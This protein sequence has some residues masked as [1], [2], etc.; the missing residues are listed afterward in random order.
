[1]VKWYKYLIH[2]N[3]SEKVSL[4][5]REMINTKNL[6]VRQQL[7]NEYFG[8]FETYLDF[9]KYFIR[10]VKDDDYKCFHEAIFN[11]AQKMYFDID[12]PL[13]V[14]IEDVKCNI[15]LK[16]KVI[17]NKQIYTKDEVVTA[18]KIL[19][20]RIKIVL[21]MVKDT[22]ILVFNSN[23]DKKCSYHIVIDRWCC[24]D[25]LDAKFLFEEIMKDYPSYYKD[26]IDKSL[27]KNLQ[28]F[29]T[30]KSKK[31]NDNRIKELDELSTWSSKGI[32]F[33]NEDQ[34][35]I[36]ILGASLVTN[37]SYCSVL[38]T[39][40]IEVEKS[41]YTG[42]EITLSKGEIDNISKL[43]D[44]SFSISEVKGTMILLKRLRP[45]YCEMCKTVHEHQNPYL[46]VTQDMNV[47]FHCRRTG[48]EKDKYLLGNIGS[49]EVPK[50]SDLLI[51]KEET[52]DTNKHD[53]V[54]E[55]YKIYSKK[56]I[57]EE[58]VKEELEKDKINEEVK[59]KVKVISGK[60]LLN[61]LK[62]INNDIDK[63]KK[64]S[65]DEKYFNS[66]EYV[67][68]LPINTFTSSNVNINDTK[69]HTNKKKYDNLLDCNSI[70]NIKSTNNK[71][72]KSP[73]IISDFFSSK[74]IK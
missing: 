69:Y 39:F 43:F 65:K 50:L 57:K 41:I 49:V 5:D 55:C 10:E 26:C 37:V 22:D 33:I 56:E 61:S 59:D 35:F 4:M 9:A 15:E 34:K 23:N 38:P 48:N 36:H 30:Y 20:N 3:D 64:Q 67:K 29:R 46:T 52:I 53:N 19:I 51:P 70:T 58:E 45:S 8:R 13:S 44:D 25:S 1:M 7:D 63:P 32:K 14:K 12:V 42:P 2:Q 54:K 31:W 66:L 21:P 68:S 6:I 27:Y 62:I 24:T 60:D 73:S 47:W 18:M 72:E 16:N 74:I 71:I 40:K 17:S 28:F 11:S